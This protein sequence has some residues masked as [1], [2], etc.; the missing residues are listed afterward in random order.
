MSFGNPTFWPPFEFWKKK[1]TLTKSRIFSATSTFMSFIANFGNWTRTMT[2]LLIEKTC[3]DIMITV[4]KQDSLQKSKISKRFALYEILQQNATDILDVC[5][6]IPMKPFSFSISY[7]FTF[8]LM[9]CPGLFRHR[10]RKVAWDEK[11]TCLIEHKPLISEE[12]LHACILGYW[13]LLRNSGLKMNKKKS[14]I[15]V[16]EVAWKYSERDKK[17]F[18]AFSY[19]T[20]F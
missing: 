16:N 4:S 15:L 17:I 5:I 1:K 7:K 12:C 8:P 11:T 20:V 19:F 14:F 2:S 6:R 9:K 3:H 10:K 18:L 13:K